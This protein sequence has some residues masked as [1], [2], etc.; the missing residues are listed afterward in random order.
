MLQRRLA[1]APGAPGLNSRPARAPHPTSHS[2]SWGALAS[3]AARKRPDPIRPR[4][5][6]GVPGR[7]SSPACRTPGLRS[8]GSCRTRYSPPRVPSESAEVTGDYELRRF[9]AEVHALGM[10]T[11]QVLVPQMRALVI[12]S[13]PAREHAAAP[14]ERE[15]DDEVGVDQVVRRPLHVEL[16]EDACGDAHLPPS[17]PPPH[18]TDVLAQANA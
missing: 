3:S 13:R 12:D 15:A 8:E 17:A 1:S 18:E 2:R 11:K 10:N 7:H 14:G 9:E 4:W 5:T 16:G 6:R